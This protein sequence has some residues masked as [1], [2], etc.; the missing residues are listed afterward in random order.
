MKIGLVPSVL[1]RA[2]KMKNFF[3]FLLSGEVKP[4]EKKKEFPMAE[5]IEFFYHIFNTPLGYV[6]VIYRE[7][8]FKIVNIRL[9]NPRKKELVAHIKKEYGGKPKRHSTKP[10]RIFGLPG[11]GWIWRASPSCRKRFWWQRRPS[12]TEN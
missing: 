7:K 8:P 9:P 4:F 5:N 12:L 1:P 2:N 11:N 3:I 6:A 10:C